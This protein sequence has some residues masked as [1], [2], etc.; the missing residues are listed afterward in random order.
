MA[1]PSNEIERI[2]RK[3]LNEE[4]DETID[5]IRELSTLLTEQV[6]PKLSKADEDVPD[7][8]EDMESEQSDVMSLSAF[9]EEDAPSIG[10]R[11]R[12]NGPIGDDENQ[13]ANLPEHDVPTPV[14]DAFATFYSTLSP[15]QAAA[16]AELFTVID[17]ELDDAGRADDEHDEK[18]V[19]AR[20]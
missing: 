4:Q 15:E 20:A 1:T 10:R 14:M 19:R 11:A 6:I 12:A 17:S 9:G 18:E 13:D 7:S 2:V 3:V 8:D 5:A 16:L